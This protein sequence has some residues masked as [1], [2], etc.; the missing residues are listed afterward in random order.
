MFGTL[1]DNPSMHITQKV[2]G[3]DSPLFSVCTLVTNFEQY[4]EMKASFAER[5]FTPERAEFLIVDNS[6]RN[7]L[8]AYRGLAEMM[9][10]ARGEYLILCHQDLLLIADGFA[11][12]E[13]ELRSLNELA[14]DWAV[15]GNSGVTHNR[16]RM[17]SISDPLGESQHRGP[18]PARVR[19]LDENFLIVRRSSG[20]RP[21]PELSGFHFYGTDLCLQAERTGRSAWVIDFHLRHLSGGRVDSSFYAEQER[22]EQHWGDL[23]GRAQLIQTTCTALILG[24]GW[25]AWWLRRLNWVRG[26]IWR[27]R[28]RFAGDRAGSRAR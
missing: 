19:S 18:L 15:A 16:Q 3:S 2:S 4:G 10:R 28:H 12:L 6:S 21:S 26:F 5:G 14:P 20:I 11:E 7:S 24:K 13:V 17:L 22:F 8:C 25:K 1:L 27:L 23:L 9:D